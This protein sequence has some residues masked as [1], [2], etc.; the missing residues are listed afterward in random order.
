MKSIIAKTA[1]ALA[2]SVGSSVAIAQSEQPQIPKKKPGQ[3]SEQQMPSEGTQKSPGAA[4]EGQAGTDPVKK[5][6]EQTEGQA[7]APAEQKAPATE[8]QT[9]SR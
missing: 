9:G 5:P 1:L 6:A 8:E 3:Q 7:Q 4:V 2:L